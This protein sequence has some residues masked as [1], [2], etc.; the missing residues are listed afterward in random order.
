MFHLLKPFPECLQM[1]GVAL[2]RVAVRA[3]TDGIGKDRAHRRRLAGATKIG[4]TLLDE[5][6]R[7]FLIKTN[8]SERN[9]VTCW[10]TSCL[11]RRRKGQSR[12]ESIIFGVEP[13]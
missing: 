4:Q 8:S 6:E 5:G 11:A 10:I 7:L 1:P 12:T 9:C 2:A 3:D 13:M